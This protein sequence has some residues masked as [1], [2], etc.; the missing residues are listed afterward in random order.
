MYRRSKYF[1]WILWAPPFLVSLLFL[2]L[3]VWQ[4][5]RARTFLP[6]SDFTLTEGEIENAREFAEW[7]AVRATMQAFT[8]WVILLALGALIW[9]PEL[10]R[11][12]RR[13]WPDVEH[14][15]SVVDL[16]A[17]TAA[18]VGVIAA[19][20]IFTVAP[21]LQTTYACATLISPEAVEDPAIKNIYGEQASPEV[22]AA[23][24][25]FV[26]GFIEVEDIKTDPSDLSECAVAE[27]YQD[28]NRR[29][30]T[31]PPTQDSDHSFGGASKSIRING[32]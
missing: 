14:A 16:L 20:D 18:V 5:H 12:A 24:L 10:R 27:S 3:L 29:S 31:T 11:G 9:I 19:L 7:N 15:R 2:G 22:T 21:R 13:W 26:K 1:V 6:P 17:K 23:Y 30:S 8:G 25:K 28:F 4:V 32:L